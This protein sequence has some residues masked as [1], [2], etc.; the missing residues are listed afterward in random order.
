M[1]DFTVD[2]WFYL[3]SCYQGGSTAVA[4]L[5]QLEPDGTHAIKRQIKLPKQMYFSFCVTRHGDFIATGDNEVH[6]FNADNT[7]EKH[8]CHSGM[9]MATVSGNYVMAGGVIFKRNATKE[10][11]WTKHMVV[12]DDDRRY[13]I[14]RS[15]TKDAFLIRYYDERA[16]KNHYIWSA[17]NPQI[18]YLKTK[19]VHYQANGELSFKKPEILGQV[20]APWGQFVKRTVPVFFD[21]TSGWMLEIEQDRG[22]FKIGCASEATE[23]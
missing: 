7:T 22:G 12:Y 20:M 9:A 11:T 1:S 19:W 13:G 16:Q 15:P 14:D 10:I 3:I 18:E 5:A 2:G 23:I 8:P 21:F 4:S 17:S 6:F